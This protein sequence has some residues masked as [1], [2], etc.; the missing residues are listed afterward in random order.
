LRTCG[1]FQK[2]LLASALALAVSTGCSLFSTRPVQTMADTA[3]ALR[4]A[5]EVEA[6]V[7]APELYREATE[8][9]TKARQ[10]YRLKQFD[11]AKG[12]ADRARVL[13][14]K[15][16]FQALRDGGKRGEELMTSEDFEAMPAAPTE[17]AAPPTEKGTP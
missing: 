10:E 8:W 14:E 13:A 11:L 1:Y 6:D 2:S 4:A 5:R 15:A 3:A 9:F 7:H 17:E 16:E 12:Y